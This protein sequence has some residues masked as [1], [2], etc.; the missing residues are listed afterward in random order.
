LIGFKRRSSPDTYLS[1]QVFPLTP[2]DRIA[3]VL[4]SH[5]AVTYTHT[6]GLYCSHFECEDLVGPSTMDFLRHQAEMI[7]KEIEPSGS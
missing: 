7:E 4:A 5:R 6:K 2:K 1:A 3:R